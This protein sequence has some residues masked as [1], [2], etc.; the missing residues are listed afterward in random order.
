[1][2]KQL[3]WCHGPLWLFVHDA[4]A[5][6]IWLPVSVICH[7]QLIVSV[8]HHHQLIVILNYNCCFWL[9]MS[10][11]KPHHWSSWCHHLLLAT[12]A[13]TMLPVPLLIPSLIAHQQLLQCCHHMP[14]PSTLLRLPVSVSHHHQ[15][16]VFLII[17]FLHHW[18]SHYC[19]SLF[20]FLMLSMKQH[21]L[22]HPATHCAIAR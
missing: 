10:F 22:Q 21:L 6:V 12:A 7:H 16:G 19:C 4:T 9:E 5:L 1:M 13:E 17:K 3:P 8:T 18:F 2:W 14:L 20:S 11:K 15:F